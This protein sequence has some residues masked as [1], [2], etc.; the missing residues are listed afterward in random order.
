MSLFY[1]ETAADLASML[2]MRHRLVPATGL[3]NFN[4]G[5]R[6]GGLARQVLTFGTDWRVEVGAGWR[7]HSD[8]TQASQLPVVSY[9]GPITG[10]RMP[11]HP[12]A[13]ATRPAA[14]SLG[15]GWMARPGNEVSTTQ[16]VS[17]AG[18]AQAIV[19]VEPV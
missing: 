1:A 17:L 12:I 9:R 18:S 7:I 13:A 6:T 14:N 11:G 10:S 15:W 8:L 19:P 4:E 2:P 3:P 16:I 5:R